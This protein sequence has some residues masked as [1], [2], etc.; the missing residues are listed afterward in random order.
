MVDEEPLCGFATIKSLFIYLSTL[1]R[2]YSNKRS[3]MGPAIHK[4][5]CN[6]YIMSCDNIVDL[7]G[8]NKLNVN[9][10]VIGLM[11]S[12][13]R[14]PLLGSELA[15]KNRNRTFKARPKIKLQVDNN[16]MLKASQAVL[17]AWV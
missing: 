1:C 6:S 12:K 14:R 2:F 16:A 17:K 5:Q 9:S 13:L 10:T 4:S 3:R 8:L 15:P 11:L 7:E